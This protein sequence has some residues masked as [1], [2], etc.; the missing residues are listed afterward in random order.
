[1]VMNHYGISANLMSLGGLAIAIG[2]MVDGSV[3]VVENVFAKLG[4]RRGDHKLKIVLDA[5]LEVGTP[6]IF[7]VGIIILV[8][9]PLMT[10]EGMEG[11]MFAPLAYT[12]AIALGI[13]LILS[14]TLSPVL[15]SFLLKGGSEH[16]TWVVAAIKRPYL[17]LLQLALDNRKK[18]IIAVLLIF[19]GSAALFPF[20]GT[21]FIPEM[22]EGSLSPNFDRVPN[23]SLD[24]SLKMEMQAIKIIRGVPDVAKVVSRLG[25]GESPADPAGPNE[26]DV[27]ATLVPIEERK[28]G[29]TQDQIADE[30]RKRLSVL[31][32]VN[33][34]M[35]QPISDRVDEMVTGVRA[36]VAVKLCGN[37]LYV[38]SEKANEIA[39]VAESVQ[40]FRDSRV[41]RVGGQQYL[42]IQIDRGA[43]AR[44][45]LNAGD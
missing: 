34:V 45:G 2:L 30:M 26:T 39:R 36:D 24:E 42:N 44:F 16:D 5:V 13:S 19:A 4:H 14:L 15:A 25:R 10:L 28:D 12:I 33:L 3:V 43:I 38:L 40:G 7:G 20:L 41:E 31:P 8:F 21:S 35:A 1:M 22:K 6:V 37:D 11:K 32:G 17:Y 9:L 18:L 23:I 27:M 29:W